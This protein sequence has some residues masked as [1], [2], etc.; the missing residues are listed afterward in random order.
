MASPPA[1]A[2]PFVQSLN[3]ARLRGW[4]SRDSDFWDDLLGPIKRQTLVPVVG[5]FVN[6]VKVGDAEQTF[7]TLIGQRLAERYDLTVRC[8][9]LR[10]TE[11]NHSVV[12]SAKYQS[13]GADGRE[14]LTPPVHINHC[15][16]LFIVNPSSL[17]Y[18][19][20]T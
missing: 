8:A 10:G 11:Q 20:V 7:T 13:R 3:S 16:D 4:S 12:A 17:R 18:R 5:P 6:T 2:M 14:S 1:P 19:E 15:D 9:D